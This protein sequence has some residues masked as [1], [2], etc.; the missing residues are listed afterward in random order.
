MN[1]GK[2][3]LVVAIVLF[4]LAISPL[5][6]VELDFGTYKV[7]ANRWVIKANLPNGDNILLFSAQMYIPTDTSDKQKSEL[8]NFTFDKDI[9]IEDEGNNKIVKGEG[10]FN[11]SVVKNKKIN[12]LMSYQVEL[13]PKGNIKLK[14][15]FVN[16]ADD[17][18][19]EPY[20]NFAVN[21]DLIK[22]QEWTLTKNAGK[23][24]TGKWPEEL[25][26]GVWS[27]DGIEEPQVTIAVLNTKLDKP[28]VC[29]LSTDAHLRL[30]SLGTN[31]LFNFS[32]FAGMYTTWDWKN[33]KKNDSCV[34]EA[35]IELPVSTKKTK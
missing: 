25:K 34:I 23:E 12:V 3:I 19:V 29:S 21:P 2:Y 33:F 17:F 24:Q 11:Q 13:S 27:I 32:Y 7:D 5:Y 18:H 14:Y 8:A 26:H 20:V 31:K 4:I 15:E 35:D 28:I 9:T 16:N 10:I 22:G 6:A 1:T 30:G